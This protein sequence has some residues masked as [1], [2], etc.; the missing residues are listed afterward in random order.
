MITLY[1]FV[2]FNDGQ[3]ENKCDSSSIDR[4]CLPFKSGLGIVYKYS[5]EHYSVRS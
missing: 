2:V 3:Q 1:M 4:Q 5:H